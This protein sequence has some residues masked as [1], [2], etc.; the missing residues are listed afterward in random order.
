MSNGRLYPCADGFFCSSKSTVARPSENSIVGGPCPLGEFC[1]NGLRNTC[2]RGRFCDQ[3]GTT[4][5]RSRILTSKLS[6]NKLK[7]FQHFLSGDITNMKLYSF[8]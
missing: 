6:K 5:F 1:E 2:E 7:K 3:L 4:R 8:V